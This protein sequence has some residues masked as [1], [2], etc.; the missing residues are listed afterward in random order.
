MVGL[1]ITVMS[2]VFC[3]A[4]IVCREETDAT[5]KHGGS[6]TLSVWVLGSV[7]LCDDEKMFSSADEE[8][9][10]CVTH[11]EALV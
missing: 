8:R 10:C 3:M 9:V 6:A 7:V 5:G 1:A 11:A 4:A 2:Y